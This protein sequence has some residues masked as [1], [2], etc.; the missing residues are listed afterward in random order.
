MKLKELIGEELFKQLPEDK[1]KEFKSKDFIDNDGS[2][3]P[4]DRFDQVNEEK[5]EYKKQLGDRDKQLEDL[6]GKVKDNEVLTKEIE[7]LKDLNSKTTTEYEGKIKTIKFNNALDSA[8]KG[9]KAKNIKAV[10]ALLDLEKISQD[11]DNLVGLNDQIESIKK[12][13]DYLF[14]KPVTGTG[15]FITGGNSQGNK[16]KEMSLGE[17]LAKERASQMKASEALDNFFK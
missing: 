10:K 5:K 9:S 16:Q 6:Q 8:L 11:G 17:K 7:S 1:Q 13:A 2:F 4:K 15:S 12:E 3:I 14:E